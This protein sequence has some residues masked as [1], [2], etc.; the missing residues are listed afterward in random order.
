MKQ[1]RL[2]PEFEPTHSYVTNCLPLDH[3]YC[4]FGHAEELTTCIVQIHIE[5]SSEHAG[6]EGCTRDQHVVI[7]NLAKFPN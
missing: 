3:T 4:K 1:S 6:H 5:A 7:H 2:R